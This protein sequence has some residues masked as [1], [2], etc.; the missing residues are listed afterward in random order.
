M[1]VVLNNVILP[2][3]ISGSVMGFVFS[4]CTCRSRS[5]NI[6]DFKNIVENQIDPHFEDLEENINSRF[7][8]L[9]DKVDKVLNL[10]ELDQDQDEDENQK[11]ND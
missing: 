8:N 3:I 5:S 2:A 4:I 7:D 1:E 10:I 6:K 9:E 11:K